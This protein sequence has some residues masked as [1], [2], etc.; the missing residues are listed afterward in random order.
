[1]KWLTKEVAA[2]GCLGLGMGCLLGTQ[3][4]IA[5]GM[6]VAFGLTIFIA[7]FVSIFTA[8]LTGTLAPLIFTF[9]FHRDSALYGGPLETA[10]Q[11]IVGSFAMV[12]MSYR[13]LV[14]LGPMDVS[15]DDICGR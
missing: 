14:F 10:I 12:I 13:L 11:D 5:S 2:A 1:M 8:G 9:V 4:F 3:A 6:D 7:Q 15:P